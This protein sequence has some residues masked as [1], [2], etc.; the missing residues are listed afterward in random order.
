MN[1][2]GDFSNSY[3]LELWRTLTST[4]QVCTLEHHGGHWEQLQR[5]Y[6]ELLKFLKILKIAGVR[7]VWF[8][9]LC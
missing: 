6:L 7:S 2:K 8:D 5:C 1:D 3:I 4:I 9:A